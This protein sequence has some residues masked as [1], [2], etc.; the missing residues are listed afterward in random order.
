M[1]PN[2]DVSESNAISSKCSISRRAL[3]SL[4]STIECTVEVEVNTLPFLD[5]LIVKRGPNLATR[6]YT[7]N[8]F[9]PDVAYVS[10]PTTPV[11]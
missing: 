9:I 2:H 7:G 6:V 10:S 11:T 8:L 5:I 3:Y 1:W 4:K